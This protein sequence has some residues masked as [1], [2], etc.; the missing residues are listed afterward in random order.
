MKGVIFDF[1]RTL[2]NPENDKLIEG[3]TDVLNAL[4]AKKYKLALLTKKIKEDRLNQIYKLG[5]E[6]YFLHIQVAEENKTEKDFN[7]CLNALRLKSRDV[8]VVGDRI[9][10]EIALAKRLGMTTFWYKSGKFA[11]ELPKAGEEPDYIISNLEELIPY[12]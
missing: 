6:S 3:A 1:N 12:F 11:S 2:Y 9:K 10:S 7:I 5:L 8:A 4:R